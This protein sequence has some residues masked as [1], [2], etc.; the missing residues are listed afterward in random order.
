MGYT[1]LHIATH[2]LSFAALGRKKKSDIFDE[3]LADSVKAR[4]DA[5]KK[6]IGDVQT[7]FALNPD[8]A[9]AD[10]EMTAAPLDGLAGAGQDL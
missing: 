8:D 2:N 1:A 4:R 10:I 6:A 7:A 9:A 5:F 3:T